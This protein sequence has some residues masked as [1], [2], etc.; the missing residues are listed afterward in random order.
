[1]TDYLT[2]ANKMLAMYL[3]NYYQQQSRSAL[4]AAM[5]LK[6]RV[7]MKYYSPQYVYMYA[8]SIRIH[9]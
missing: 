2:N 5:D 8:E 3:C 9:L 7:M 4:A 1:M 6:P